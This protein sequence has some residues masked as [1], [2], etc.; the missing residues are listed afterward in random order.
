MITGCEPGVALCFKEPR[1]RV[2]FRTWFYPSYIISIDNRYKQKR[3][4][5]LAT[6]TSNHVNGTFYTK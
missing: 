6:T 5:Y 4:Q 3:F 1:N 2:L